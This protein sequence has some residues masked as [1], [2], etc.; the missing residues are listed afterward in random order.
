MRIG[1]IGLGRMGGGMAGN[2]LRNGADLTVFD[3]SEDAC[4][5]FVDQ[6]AK[7]AS[8]L[9]ALV[10]G[11]DVIFMSLPGPNEVREVVYGPGGILANL[12][13]DAVLVDLST[14]SR[15]LAIQI[16]GDCREV[17]AHML[18]APVSGGPAGAASGD[19]A[20]WVGGDQDVYERCLPTFR[21]MGDKPRLCGPIGSGTVVKLVNNMT[22]Y[23]ILMTLA[24]TFSM[25]VKA[26]VDPLELWEALRLGVVGKASPL[27]M[28][29]AQ[30]LPGKYEEPAFALRLAYKDVKLATELGRELDVPLRNCNLVAAEMLEAVVKGFG[31]QDSRAYLKLQLE[32]AGV[33]I[34]VDDDRLSTAFDALARNVQ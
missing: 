31:D 17:E 2:L 26:G 7:A 20:F 23:C 27:D 15:A 34:A 30:F 14:S 28:L 13:R 18:D 6:G 16:Y 29:R 32:R 19:L 24:E 1:F 22:G 9:G 5:S 25:G 3:M 10:R 4:A 8:D 33:E 11:A 12:A 21:M